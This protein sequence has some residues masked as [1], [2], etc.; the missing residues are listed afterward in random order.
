MMKLNRV[1]RL[2]SHSHIIVE[3]GIAYFTTDLD[4]NE[5]AA[6]AHVAMYV[7]WCRDQMQVCLEWLDIAGR[8]ED[9][10]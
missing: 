7:D 10:P 9:K 8:E 6:K 4:L 1:V 3:N 5:T 2:D